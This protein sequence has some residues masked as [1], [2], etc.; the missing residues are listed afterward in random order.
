MVIKNKGSASGSGSHTLK[1][2]KSPKELPLYTNPALT[3]SPRHPL[4][5]TAKDG[6]LG[7]KYL[8]FDPYGHCSSVLFV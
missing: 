7:D 4:V 3:V 8:W 6:T 2:G 5:A 1:P